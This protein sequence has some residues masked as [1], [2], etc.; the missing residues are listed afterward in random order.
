MK[1]NNTSQFPL[2]LSRAFPVT[3]AVCLTCLAT[4]V[5]AGF[6][7]DGDFSSFAFD[8]NGTATVT[9][10]ATGGNP[11]SRL[12]VTT[13]SGSTVYGTAI[14]TDFVTTSALAG[15][16]FTLEL[17]V[18]SGPGSFGQGQGID[19]L[20]EQNGVI[21]RTGLGITGYPLNWDTLS[22]TGTFNAGSFILLL[23]SGPANPDFNG[24]VAT[25]F[26]FSGR[27]TNSGTLTQYYDNFRL[28]S[29]AIEASPVPEPSTAFLLGLGS[30]VICWQRRRVAA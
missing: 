8:T 29:S 24:G 19:L 15:A 17:D 28:E 7:V 27:N 18:L 12:N 13:V 4:P 6:I 14:K 25:R 20:V 2:M 9:R 1:M 16:T 5:D 22:F 21:Y 3:L 26:G 10:E 23:G 30:A 11:G